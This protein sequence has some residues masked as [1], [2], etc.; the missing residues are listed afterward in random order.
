[1]NNKYI[2]LI[3][4]YGMFLVLIALVV[5][6]TI[7]SE[8]FL[9]TGNIFNIARQISMTSIAAVGM[10]FVLLTGGIDLTIGSQLTLVNI[11]GAWLIINGKVN[12]VLACAIAILMS[13]TIGFFNGLIIA[14]I[15]M[16]P[17]VATLSMMIIL[18]GV[19]YLICGGLPI[20]GFDKSFSTLGQGYVWIIPI[21]VIIMVIILILGT[22]ILNSTYF[23][24]YF[25]AVG[26]NE[27]A[28]NLSGINVVKIKYLVY[29]LSGFFCGIAGIIMLSRTNSGQVLSGK[30]YEMDVLTSCV[31]GGVSVSGGYGRISNVVVGTLILGVLANG[32]V[33][34]NVS[35]YAQMVLKGAVLLVAVAFDCIQKN[36]EKTVVLSRE[37][38]KVEAA[39]NK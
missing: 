12:P 32:L 5:F 9:T 20:F 2:D 31:L 36:R 25:Y 11:V 30:G 33:M 22:F 39:H 8:R 38:E 37:D 21:P 29:T 15:K 23:G 3:K 34:L 27:D 26:S 1:M 4:R 14:K 10:T 6:F 18:E 17:M 16:P 13:T 19:A 24:R 35:H 28:A 7:T